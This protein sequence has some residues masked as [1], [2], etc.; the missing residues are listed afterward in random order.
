MTRRAVVT[1]LKYEKKIIIKLGEK[2]AGFFF[3]VCEGRK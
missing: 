3:L 1:H 2:K